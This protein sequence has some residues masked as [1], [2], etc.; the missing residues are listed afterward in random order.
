[1]ND[2]G[3]GSFRFISEDEDI[4]E[5]GKLLIEGQFYDV[6]GIEV[7]AQLNLDSSGNLFELDVWKMDSTPLRQWPNIEH[8]KI[9]W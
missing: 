5:F 6:D 3:M 1:M 2:G 8:V 9:L 7:S 4:R